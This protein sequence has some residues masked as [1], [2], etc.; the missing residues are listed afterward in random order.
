MVKIFGFRITPFFLFIL[1]MECLALL[2]SVY[3]GLSLYQGSPEVINHQMFDQS[4]HSGLMVFVMLL[5][6][7]PG[8]FSQVKII[9]K[10]K[11]AVS[12]Y[13]IGISVSLLTMSIIVFSNYSS[14][15]TKML[16]G[17]A[18]LSACIGLC[19][20]QLS[21]VGKYWRFLIRSGVN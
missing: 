17:M 2:L 19:V 14:I 3:L 13:L 7:T 20:S 11:K 16:F 9:N 15:N 5:I 4:M 18:L 8:F 21:I 1:G 10:I 6:L 12:Q